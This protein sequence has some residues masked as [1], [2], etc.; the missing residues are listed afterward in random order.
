MSKNNNKTALVTGAS[1]GIGSAIAL[2]LAKNGFTVIGTATSDSGAVEITRRLS[3]LQGIGKVLDVTD[4]ESIERL[5]IGIR[6]E[7]AEQCGRQSGQYFIAHERGRVEPSCRYQ[8][9]CTVST[10]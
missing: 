4:P 6:K 9:Y 1:R 8:S 3:G 5:M 2:A 7:L 10:Q